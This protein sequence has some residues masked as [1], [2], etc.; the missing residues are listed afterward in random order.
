[1]RL[2][3]TKMSPQE[4]KEEIGAPAVA[5]AKGPKWPYELRI[6]LD[7]EILERLKS[8]VGDFKIGEKLKIEATG[9]VIELEEVARVGS[10]SRQ[11]VEIQIIE[12]GY[13]PTA[14]RRQD[15]S[16]ARHLDSIGQPRS[17]D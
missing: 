12:I 10:S 16:T 13:E 14:G 7:N 3:S 6:R 5:K 9:Q 4:A 17:A 2:V 8:A 1:M 11:N 15:R